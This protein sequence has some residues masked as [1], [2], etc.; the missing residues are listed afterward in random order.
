[1]RPTANRLEHLK[2]WTWGAYADQWE[3][4]FRRLLD[5]VERHGD[6]RVPLAHEMDGFNLGVWVNTQRDAR[7]RQLG[8][9]REHRLKGLHR[10]TWNPHA[11]RWDDG[12]ARLLDYVERHGDANVPRDYGLRNTVFRCAARLSQQPPPAGLQF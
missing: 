6:A 11:E 4:G 1:L 3:E 9:D 8:T 10:W 2:D 12:L 7:Q 5:Y